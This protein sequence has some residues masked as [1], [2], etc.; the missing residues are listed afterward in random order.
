MQKETQRPPTA[1]GGL[2]CDSSR[3]FFIETS[4]NKNAILLYGYQF[5][6]ILH[7]IPLSNKNFD[8]HSANKSIYLC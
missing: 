4:G 2:F 6:L 5:F 1:V 8:I 3:Q 7:A